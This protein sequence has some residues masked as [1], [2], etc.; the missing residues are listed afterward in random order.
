MKLNK[1]ISNYFAKNRLSLTER[2][3]SVSRKEKQK[4]AELRALIPAYEQEKRIFIK[5]TCQ[6][7]IDDFLV[8]LQKYV[9]DNPLPEKKSANVTE[10]P[11]TEI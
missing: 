4:I 11:N 2:G 5:C 3:Q 10:Q 1:Q 7:S 8:L 9:K 6:S